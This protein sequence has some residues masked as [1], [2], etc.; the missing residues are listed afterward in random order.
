MP[1]SIC[2]LSFKGVVGNFGPDGTIAAFLP[3]GFW[4][5]FSYATLFNVFNLLVCLVGAKWFGR[6]TAVILASVLLCTCVTM[7]SFF[8]NETLV[9]GFDEPCIET[10]NQT[11]ID[12]C[13]HDSDTFRLKSEKSWRISYSV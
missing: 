5:N 6:T 8:Q 11:V 3:S 7:G 13:R 4:W 12:N 9:I 10:T 2:K 1:F